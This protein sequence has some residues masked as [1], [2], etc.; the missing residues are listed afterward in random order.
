MPPHTQGLNEL[1]SKG[2]SVFCIYFQEPL[3]KAEELKLEGETFI[4]D[5]HYAVDCIMPK[6]SEL[7][8]MYKEHRSLYEARKEMLET[9]LDLQQR[10][11]RVGAT[12]YVIRS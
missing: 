4:A 8:R 10:I 1:F 6:C 9:S 2:S 5:E 11:D 7:E 3:Q 12:I